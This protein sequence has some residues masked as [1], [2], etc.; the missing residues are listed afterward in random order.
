MSLKLSKDNGLSAFNEMK[1]NASRVGSTV[2]KYGDGIKKAG[3][4]VGKFYKGAV[5]ARQGLE[6]G[7]KTGGFKGALR[8]MIKGSKAAQNTKL[9]W[10]DDVTMKDVRAAAQQAG[11]QVGVKYMNPQASKLAEANAKYGNVVNTIYK[12]NS[13]ITKKVDKKKNLESQRDAQA[14]SISGENYNKY[15]EQ[16]NTS[17][18]TAAKA[19]VLRQEAAAAAAAPAGSEA[20]NA[21]NSKVEERKKQ[22]LANEISKKEKQL[23]RSLSNDE[24]REM[25]KANNKKWGIQTSDG[26]RYAAGD[27]GTALRDSSGKP[28]ELTATQMDG[29]ID[30]MAEVEARSTK[31]SFNN[32]I[33][34]KK[35]ADFARELAKKEKELGRTLSSTDDE[36]IKLQESNN[37]KWG[38]ANDDGDWCVADDGGNS[39]GVLMGDSEIASIMSKLDAELYKDTCKEEIDKLDG[40]IAEERAKL[41]NSDQLKQALINETDTMIHEQQKALSDKDVKQAYVNACETVM[42]AFKKSKEADIVIDVAQK[43]SIANPENCAEDFDMLKELYNVIRK[44]SNLDDDQKRALKAIVDQISK[45][46]K[47]TD[48][49]VGRMQALYAATNDIK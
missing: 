16:K 28:I 43:L 41:L 18:N 27:D 6:A 20:R 34:A 8:G 26:K 25:L 4:N 38:T 35:H 12:D 45:V 13:S 14:A 42:K 10:L 49:E 29:L 21:W 37:K 46:A 7:A 32:E 15:L 40:E 30:S 1:S 36:Y 48:A 11:R 31:E 39:T 22:D 3:Q 24:K 33:E 44:Q 17:G 2:K 19:N 47:E 9:S 5:G 23:G